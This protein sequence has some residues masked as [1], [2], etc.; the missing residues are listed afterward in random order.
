MCRHLPE[1]VPQA[2]AAQAQRQLLAST[3]MLRKPSQWQS[4]LDKVLCVTAL[5]VLAVNGNAPV[6][7]QVQ[8]ACIKPTQV[9]CQAVPVSVHD[10][11]DT[12]PT[13]EKLAV[14][15]P[16]TSETG[17]GTLENWD[18]KLQGQLGTELWHMMS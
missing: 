11:S 5:N 16:G 10:Q 18:T 15:Q 13:E 3:A 1:I 4:H 12:P 7:L 14:S 17:H 6:Q 8:L 9:L 2:L